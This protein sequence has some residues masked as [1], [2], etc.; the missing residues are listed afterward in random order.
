MKKYWYTVYQ[1]QHLGMTLNA[2]FTFSSV[3][4]EFPLTMARRT[5]KETNKYEKPVLI[6]SWTELTQEQYDFEMANRKDF[7]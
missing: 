2:S 1:T 4:A 5:I 6:I 3:D 7:E